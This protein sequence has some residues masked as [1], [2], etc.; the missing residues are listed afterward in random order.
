MRKLI[1]AILLLT[2][3]TVEAQTKTTKKDTVKYDYFVKISVQN[4]QTL[5]QVANLYKN[6]VV[7]SPTLTDKEKIDQQKQ[8]D[9]FLNQKNL[10]PVL[11]SVK[12]SNK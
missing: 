10:N 4:Y 12:V 9:S 6:T 2:S 1:I 8:L 11:D 3:L 5:V 7:Y